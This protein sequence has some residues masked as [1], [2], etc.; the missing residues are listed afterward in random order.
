MSLSNPNEELDELITP[1]KGIIGKFSKKFSKLKIYGLLLIIGIIFGILFGHYYIEPILT[2][3]SSICK[4]CIQTN[5]ILSQENECLYTI[6]PK[7]ID[8]TFCFDK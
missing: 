3:E 8:I 7:D 5:Q 6:L 2:E 4:N 1:K